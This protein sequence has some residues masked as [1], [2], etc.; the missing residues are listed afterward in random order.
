MI[1]YSLKCCDGHQ[2]DSWFQSAA[3]FDKLQNANM[4][5]CVT[6][7]VSEVTK[8][9]MTPAV[10]PARKGAPLGQPDTSNSSPLSTPAGPAEQMIADIR[11][12][13][14]ANSEYVGN[15]FATQARAMHDGDAPEKAIYGEAKLD[16]ARKL[17]EDGVPVL[18]LPFRPTGKDN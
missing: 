5:T 11:E 2:F 3:A 7:G 12:K 4:V 14:E 13:V 10:R 15:D 17:L 1:Q 18:P 9:L 8:V 16:E 6:C